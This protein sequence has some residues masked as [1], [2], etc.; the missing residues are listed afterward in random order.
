MKRRR[1]DLA[2]SF[3]VA[4]AFHGCLLA[5]WG[6]AAV[7][8]AG[9]DL[10][11]SFSIG[12]SSL[13]MT[14]VPPEAPATALAAETAILVQPQSEAP[15]P[16]PAPAPE[17]ETAS[18]TNAPVEIPEPA[19]EIITD[20]ESEESVDSGV[21]GPVYPSSVLRPAYPRGAR[22]RGEQGS[23]RVL[24]RVNT[25]GRAADV[26]LLESSGYALLDNAALKSAGKAVYTPAVSN[27]IPREGETILSF[28]FRLT[29]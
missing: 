16:A 1:N 25:S 20:A 8:P 6:T 17:P 15:A 11:P 5:L 12:K 22:L 4:V 10:V 9:F 29:E 18:T 13:E 27:S 7:S 24:V 19:G 2:A 14:L 3:A 23:V 21:Q 28:E 26:R